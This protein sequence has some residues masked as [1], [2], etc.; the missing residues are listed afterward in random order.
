MTANYLGERPR[1]ASPYDGVRPQLFADMNIA[2]RPTQEE[3]IYLNIENL[4]D[5]DDITTSSTSTYYTL[6][7]NFMLGYERKF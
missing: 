3:K 1:D 7:I 5:R 4:F 2:Y 6:G